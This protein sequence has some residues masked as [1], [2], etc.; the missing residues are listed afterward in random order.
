MT[1]EQTA[2][3]ILR[4]ILTRTANVHA[5]LEHGTLTLNTRMQL[6]PDETSAL[7]RWT[8]IHEHIRLNPNRR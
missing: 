4:Q 7:Q 2:A 1:D 8:G 6:T 5:D 3:D